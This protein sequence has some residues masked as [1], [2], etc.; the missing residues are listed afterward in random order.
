MAS[1][2]EG[3][4]VREKWGGNDPERICGGEGPNSRVIL[5]DAD[6]RKGDLFVL[7]HGNARRFDSERIILQIIV[8]GD[9]GDD[10]TVLI[11]LQK[12]CKF[13]GE[14]LTGFSQNLR[15]IELV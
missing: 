6:K 9:H 14:R 8:T 13:R 11:L 4:G 12:I 5:S 3:G 15:R 10:N 1:R 2:H 7:R